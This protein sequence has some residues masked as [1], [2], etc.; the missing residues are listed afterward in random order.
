[1]MKWQELVRNLNKIH[2]TSV[3]RQWEVGGTRQGPM[4]GKKQLPQSHF[5]VMSTGR[6]S[7]A[8][9]SGLV[10]MQIWRL[11]VR[12]T[13]AAGH[14]G[15]GWMGGSLQSL[16]SARLC[17][18]RWNFTWQSRKEPG[19]VNIKFPRVHTWRK[20]QRSE[21]LGGKSYDHPKNSSTQGSVISTI[22]LLLGK[23]KTC[24]ATEELISV[25]QN[26]PAHKK[27]YEINTGLFQEYEDCLY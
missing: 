9:S 7:G 11:E 21:H 6:Q 14:C 1:M 4:R 27:N 19:V 24:N 20:E 22:A 5:S 25:W 23:P 2:E 15:L 18:P 12:E 8:Q 16:M 13:R 10:E 26:S 17:V 3:F